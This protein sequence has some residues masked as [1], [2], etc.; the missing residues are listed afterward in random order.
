[1]K[2]KSSSNSFDPMTLYY[3]IVSSSID[4]LIKKA[5]NVCFSIGIL[6]W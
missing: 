1:M 4:F 2:L 6:S 3:E 5:A